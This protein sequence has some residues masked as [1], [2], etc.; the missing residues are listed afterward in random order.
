MKTNTT[1]FVHCSATRPSQDID[2]DTIRTWHKAKGWSD[3]GYNYVI[4]R[5]GIVQLGRDLDGDG[6]VDE[7]VGAHVRGHNGS[8][9]GIC[10]VGG[11]DDSGKP[12]A[13]FTFG[14][15]A[16]LYALIQQLL[17]KHP[18]IKEVKGHRDVSSKACPSFDIHAFLN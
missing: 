9:I 8:S 16:A 18:S 14:Q 3:I 6:D 13:N 7:E 1:I 12:D 17:N 10:M 15:Y 2:A 11:I 4:T 5:A